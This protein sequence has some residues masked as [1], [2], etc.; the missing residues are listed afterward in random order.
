MI[1]SFSEYTQSLNE[2]KS[3]DD[4]KEN[5]RP[6]SEIFDGFR[7]QNY[8]YLGKF[9]WNYKSYNAFIDD[10]IEE[11]INN[12]IVPIEEEV[13][14]EIKIPVKG[15]GLD[16]WHT[17]PKYYNSYKNGVV[18]KYGEA[19]G[20]QINKKR[21]EELAIFIK[22]TSS[23]EN[24]SKVIDDDVWYCMWNPTEKYY[25]LMTIQRGSDDIRTLFKY[26]INAKSLGVDKFKEDLIE[27]KKEQEIEHAKWEE[28]RKKYQEEDDK[29]K[30]VRNFEKSIY[31]DYQKNPK[32]Y[33]K[34][35]INKLPEDIK[36]QLDITDKIK[37]Y[38][39]CDYFEY[40]NSHEINRGY[41][42]ET[43]WYVNNREMTDG[44]VYT[45]ECSSGRYMGD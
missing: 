33:K 31:D 16:V 3:L 39:E 45:T 23:K 22:N 6:L 36:K 24:V 8:K 26:F 5:R 4:F 34:T 25:Y 28:R 40:G 20:N 11:Y 37:Q 13:F 30:W 35:T 21:E 9:Y 2:M 41:D 15:I 18:D 32:N 10:N 7:K 27:E 38:D 42:I 12:V 1:K 43:T 14:G 44:W 17:V 19:R 29:K